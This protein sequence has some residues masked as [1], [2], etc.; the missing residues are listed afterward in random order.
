MGITAITIEN[1]KG[2]HEPITIE[3]KPITL[4]FGPNSSGK[5]TVLQALHYAREIF[6]RGN[7]D[8]DFTALGGTSLNL[9]GFVSL[10]HNRDLNLPISLRFNFDVENIDL[11]DFLPK[12]TEFV[13]ISFRNQ[14]T[15]NEILNLPKSGWVK[16]DVRWD[17]TTNRPMIDLLEIGINQTIFCQFRPNLMNN[18]LE[19]LLFESPLLSSIEKENEFLNFE[20]NN[21]MSPEDQKGGAENVDV[22]Y[23][24]EK[25]QEERSAS[26]DYIPPQEDMQEDWGDKLDDMESDYYTDDYEDDGQ[27]HREDDEYEE[28]WDDVQE[29]DIIDQDFEEKGPDLPPIEIYEEQIKR[30]PN[31]SN[32][33]ENGTSV[34]DNQAKTR[35]PMEQASILSLLNKHVILKE[36]GEDESGKAD[37]IF[38]LMIGSLITVIVSFIRES[39][40]KLRYVG[41]LRELPARNFE[42][43]KS[44]DDSRWSRGL[45][46]WDILHNSEPSF[47]RKVNNW[48]EGSEN[49]NAGYTALIKEFREIPVDSPLMTA[50]TTGKLLDQ[51]QEAVQA[52]LNLPIKRRVVLKEK[53]NGI[54]VLPSEVGTGISQVFPVV[55]AA[56]HTK[57]GIVVIEQPELHI[58]PAFQVA[59]GDLFITE[60]Q[61]KDIVFLLETHSEHLMLRLLRRIRETTEGTLPP[62]KL[63][64][65]PKNLAVYFLEQTEKATHISKIR[66]DKEGEFIDKWPKGFFDEREE[67]LFF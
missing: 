35:I 1:F 46:A 57:S 28:D 17:K 31:D 4:L 43:A 41:P 45:A 19:L 39:L 9:G 65:D 25:Y 58:H 20:F 62:G 48:L 42:A 22:E 40:S 56:V 23:D 63:P 7:I 33:P 60:S 27:S 61:G 59:L 51:D 52:L 37:L 53:H 8:P 49:L 3:F 67:E 29:H 6:E 44:R 2:I 14:D 21:F 66:V 13:E 16:I 54:E 55:V 10:V 5:S 15:I 26:V 32:Y 34:Q 38:S 18:R 47:V 64:L 36:R 11:S 24:W 30:K 50:L 12:T